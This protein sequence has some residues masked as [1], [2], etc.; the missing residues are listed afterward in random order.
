MAQLM[1]DVVEL[2]YLKV[3]IPESEKVFVCNG[4]RR[5]VE[6]ARL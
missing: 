1:V 2:A 6:I 4:L 3:S 5:N